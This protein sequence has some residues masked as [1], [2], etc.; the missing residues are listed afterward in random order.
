MPR[1]RWIKVV[2]WTCGRT[3]EHKVWRPRPQTRR[4]PHSFTASEGCFA[5]SFSPLW[6]LSALTSHWLTFS[7]CTCN[8]PWR[9][10]INHQEHQ[11]RSAERASP[12]SCLI[13]GNSSVLADKPALCLLSGERKPPTSPGSKRWPSH[14]ALDQL[15]LLWFLF[16]IAVACERALTGL[17]R[18]H[19][20]S[21][22]WWF[23]VSATMVLFTKASGEATCRSWLML[24]RKRGGSTSL[25]EKL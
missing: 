25:Q 6:R 19:S 2:W 12:K 23:E 13:Q 11:E 22:T 1:E 21:V 3:D 24:K 9:I 16:F 15:L 5:F 7:L 20:G 10:R 14:R 8:G 18:V 4:W 17:T